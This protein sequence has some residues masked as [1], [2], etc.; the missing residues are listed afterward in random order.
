VTT[1]KP[2][3]RDAQRNRD[4]L[5]AAARRLFAARGLDVP[6]E[7]IAKEA[8]VSIGTLYN[9]FPTRG[10]LVE[11]ALAGK[12]AGMVEQAELALTMADPWEG[13]ASFLARCCEVQAADRGYNELCVRVLPD[14]PEIDRL[15]ARGHE[16]VVTILDRAQ[17]SGQLRADFH[18]G[19]LAFVLWSTTTIIDAT[20]ASA[21]EAW[22]RHLAFL[23]DGLRAPAAHPLPTPPLSQEEVA[24]AMRTHGG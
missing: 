21:P 8:G 4:L 17:R 5:V 2:L 12:V 20:A 6:L 18:E 9:R 22:R 14:T 16:L 19:D 10:G 23:L 15:K 1:S 11:A 3:R 13:F 24:A 7:D